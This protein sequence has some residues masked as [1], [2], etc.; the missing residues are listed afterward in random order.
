MG[1]CVDRKSDETDKDKR[2]AVLKLRKKPGCG[3]NHQESLS[4]CLTNTVHMQIGHTQI[5]S[6][7]S[8]TTRG[9]Q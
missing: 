6:F 5:P 9:T 2:S 4:I 3:A 1:M 8:V 7:V